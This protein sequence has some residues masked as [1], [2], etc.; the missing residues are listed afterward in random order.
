MLSA[1]ATRGLPYRLSYL[2]NMLLLSTPVNSSRAIRQGFAN[3]AWLSED[4]PPAAAQEG[5]QE[6]ALIWGGEDIDDVCEALGYS[7]IIPAFIGAQ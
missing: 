7:R 1:N 3:I 2:Y 5:E 6:R 4:W